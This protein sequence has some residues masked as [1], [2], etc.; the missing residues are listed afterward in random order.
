[1]FGCLLKLC[2]V[3]FIDLSTKKSTQK[4]EILYYKMKTPEPLKTVIIF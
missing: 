1:M 2:Q 3:H 4:K